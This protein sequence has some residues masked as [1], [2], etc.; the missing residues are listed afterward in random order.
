MPGWENEALSAFND[1]H[2]KFVDAGPLYN[3]I[4]NF[5]V[6][7]S[8]KLD[9]L[10]KTTT[11]P[12]ARSSAV[13]RP[14]GTVR[15]SDERATLA[16]IGGAQGELRGIVTM[17]YQVTDESGQSVKTETAKIYHASAQVAPDAATA[18][19]IEWVANLAS[20]SLIW[21]DPI[22]TETVDQKTRTIG[23]DEYKDCASH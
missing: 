8:D 2:F 22:R 12:D 16:S 11:P 19:V 5:Q 3:P 10:L 17:G 20:Q 6:S 1:W 13:E 23:R 9:I 15:I 14:S 18:N 4:T 7:R 21:P